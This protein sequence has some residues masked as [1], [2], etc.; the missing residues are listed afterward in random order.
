MSGVDNIIWKDIPGYEGL[1]QASKCGKIKRLPIL[2]SPRPWVMNKDRVLQLSS[3]RGYYVYAG[4]K[5]D[6]Q[7]KTCP[8]HR[9]IALTF[10]PNPHNKPHINHKD[11][12]KTNN[13][14]DNLEWCTPQENTQHWADSVRLQQESFKPGMP[15]VVKKT[16]HEAAVV[17]REGRFLFINPVEKDNWQGFYHYEQLNHV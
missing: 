12:D 9:L 4:L 2:N 3:Y 1:Y 15:V 10:I 14:V 17:R 8:V 7:T 13:C 16:G 11:L 5:K 6:R